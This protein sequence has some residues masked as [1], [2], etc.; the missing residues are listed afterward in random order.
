[1]ALSTGPVPMRAVPA[2]ASQPP[3]PVTATKRPGEALPT[4]AA[5]A[6]ARTEMPAA[7]PLLTARPNPYGD[8]RRNTTQ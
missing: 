6:K 1:M 8:M 4:K 7:Q 2:I 3:P 5:P